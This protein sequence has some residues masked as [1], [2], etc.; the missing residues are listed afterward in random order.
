M[1]LTVPPSVAIATRKAGALTRSAHEEATVCIPH[2]SI[3]KGRVTSGKMD[4]GPGNERRIAQL[5]NGDRFDGRS[6]TIG[7]H[8]R[9]NAR[10]S[11]GPGAIAVTATPKGA[12]SR[13]KT[14]VR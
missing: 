3:G 14:L 12:R 10:T 7:G 8:Q 11:S 4:G 6:Q 13:A 9:A 2:C 1:T 5:A